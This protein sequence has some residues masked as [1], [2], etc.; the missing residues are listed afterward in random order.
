MEKQMI[1]ADEGDGVAAFVQQIEQKT[2]KS[3]KSVHIRHAGSRYGMPNVDTHETNVNISLDFFP[4]QTPRPAAADSDSQTALLARFCAKYGAE[5]GI[6][7]YQVG[8]D[9]PVGK[10]LDAASVERL[11]KQIDSAN[12]SEAAK[13]F[14][15]EHLTFNV[16]GR[17][18]GHFRTTAYWDDAYDL[19]KELGKA[20]LMMTTLVYLDHETD[21]VDYRTG[22][23]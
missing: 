14:Y 8:E 19:I 6:R 23:K 7:R 20:G 21:I 5:E 9:L 16:V 12:V 15:R 2:G 4:N 10:P 1:G 3:L 11:R 22:A 18:F 13:E 17:D